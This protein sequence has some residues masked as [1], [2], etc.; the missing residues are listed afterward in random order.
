MEQCIGAYRAKEEERGFDVIERLG[1][2]ME[3][4]REGG[5][6]AADF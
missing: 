1:E 6:G 4:E 3:E 5:R 2:K